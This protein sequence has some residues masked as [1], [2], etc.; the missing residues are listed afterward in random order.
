LKIIKLKNASRKNVKGVA[1]CRKCEYP[2]PEG[3]AGQC[4]FIRRKQQAAS[5][6]SFFWNDNHSRFVLLFFTE[7]TGPDAAVYLG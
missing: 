6:F 1:R 4:G 2:F 3:R 5:C 7:R